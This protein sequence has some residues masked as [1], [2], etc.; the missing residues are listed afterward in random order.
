MKAGLRRLKS[1]ESEDIGRGENYSL[2]KKLSFTMQRASFD[3]WTEKY[4][5]WFESPVGRY[6]KKY[7]A[8]LLLEL[9]SPQPGEIILDV[10]C[11][12]GLFTEMVLACGAKVTGIDVSLPMLA[13]AV[14]RTDAEH[15]SGVCGD[16]C[17]LPFADN[18]FTKVFSMTAIEFVEDGQQVI[19]ELERVSEKGG[20]LVVTTL[21]SLSPWAARRKEKGRHGHDLFQNI[22]FRSPSDLLALVSTDAEVRTAIHFQKDD[23]ATLIPEIEQKGKDMQID[24]GAFLAVQ[25]TKSK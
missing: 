19:R 14:D 9:L 24:T 17:A 5:S 13:K 25:W 11:G 16:M 21:N 18:S 1:T 23:P 10:G 15:F 20:L 3:T 4:D 6:V 22:F 2:R 12:S 8:E 7:E